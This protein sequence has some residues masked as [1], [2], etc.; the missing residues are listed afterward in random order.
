MQNS[1]IN[2]FEFQAS[3]LGTI[4]Q[5]YQNAFDWKFTD[6]GPEYTAF[7]ESG[8]IIYHFVLAGT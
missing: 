1:H 3:D 2:Y 7:S 6:Y 8:S 5:F 4:K